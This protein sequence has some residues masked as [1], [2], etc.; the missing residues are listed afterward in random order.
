M[1]L[2]Q[3]ILVNLKKICKKKKWWAVRTTTYYDTM[4][5]GQTGFSMCQLEAQGSQNHYP[6]NN[7]IYFMNFYTI[8]M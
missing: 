3:E 8:E 6:L 5:D 1:F 7:F 2:Q 4:K